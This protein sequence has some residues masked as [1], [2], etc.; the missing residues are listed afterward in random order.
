M[1]KYDR[2]PKAPRIFR[3]KEEARAVREQRVQKQIDARALAQAMGEISGTQ[4]VSV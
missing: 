4:E 2:L 3:T 1:Q